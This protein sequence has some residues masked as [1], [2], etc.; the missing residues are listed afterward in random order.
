MPAAVSP[1]QYREATDEGVAVTMRG[2]QLR[3]Y[4]GSEAEQADAT[5]RRRS[6]TVYTRLRPELGTWTGGSIWESAHVLSQYLLALP[7]P[8]AAITCW[9]RTRVLELGCGVGLA[10]FVAACLGA[11]QVVLTDRI[12]HIAK[13]NRDL[14]FPPDEHERVQ[15]RELLWGTGI[16]AARYAAALQHSQFVYAHWPFVL[17]D[18]LLQSAGAAPMHRVE[19]PPFDLILGT[20]LL[21]ERS[22]HD[23]LA[24]TMTALSKPGTVALLCTPDG[25]ADDRHHPFFSRMRMSGW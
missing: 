3:L 22:Q 1:Q 13:Y 2:R 19:L 15:V 12:T 23:A 25:R 14:N 5:V 11:Q 18:S 9:E 6:E 17:L 16:G 10:G 8:P 21:Y 4:S 24:E 7:S 20:D